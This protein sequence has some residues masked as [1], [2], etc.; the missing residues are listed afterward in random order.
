MNGKVRLTHVLK[1]TS[2]I[3]EATWENLTRGLANLWRRMAMGLFW[4]PHWRLGGGG[5]DERLGRQGQT[6]SLVLIFV[7][8]HTSICEPAPEMV[9]T[10]LAREERGNVRV[11]AGRGSKWKISKVD[12]VSMHRSLCVWE[13]KYEHKHTIYYSH[14]NILNMVAIIRDKARQ[15]SSKVGWTLGQCSQS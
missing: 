7:N 6:T 11:N 1:D 13:N 9:R 12:V 14:L 8:L 10:G 5:G 3:W 2:V 4:D 15:I